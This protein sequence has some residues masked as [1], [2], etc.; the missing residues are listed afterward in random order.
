MF[1]NNPYADV[2]VAYKACQ[3]FGFALIGKFFRE[4]Y[5]CELGEFI[6]E[7]NILLEFGT[8]TFPA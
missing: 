3:W 5:A 7:S 6:I 8:I 4:F 1:P 2:V